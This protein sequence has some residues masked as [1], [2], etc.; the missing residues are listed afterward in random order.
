MKKNYFKILMAIAI[1]VMTGVSFTSCDEMLDNPVVD[2]TEAET[3]DLAIE[4]TAQGA[5]ITINK[6]S[7]V[8]R[9]HC[10]VGSN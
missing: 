4:E 10:Y 3:E 5:K 7:A 6:L 9:D 2:P 8:S 1:M